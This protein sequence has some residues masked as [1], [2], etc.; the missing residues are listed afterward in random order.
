MFF[1]F[2]HSMKKY[3]QYLGLISI[4]LG[5][6]LFIIHLIVDYRG[7]ELLLSGLAFVIG[8]TVAFVKLQ[9]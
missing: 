6:L 5:L 3:I 2:L 4:T 8:G 9:R 7:N 1:V